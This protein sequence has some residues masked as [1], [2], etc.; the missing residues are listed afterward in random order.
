MMELK[1]LELCPFI[2]ELADLEVL[3]FN[4]ILKRQI[5]APFNF[6]YYYARFL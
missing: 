4:S 5:I 3:E 1:F 6:N 2:C